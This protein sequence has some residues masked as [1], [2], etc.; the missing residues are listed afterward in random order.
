[1]KKLSHKNIE[2]IDFPAPDPG[3][4]PGKTLFVQKKWLKKHSNTKMMKKI[5]L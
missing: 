3:T 4:M 5:D 1:M 2:K